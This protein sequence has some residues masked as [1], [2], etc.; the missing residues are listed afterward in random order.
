MSVARRTARARSALVARLGDV[1]EVRA[2]RALQ[3][4]AADGRDVAQLPRGAGQQGGREQRIALPHRAIGGEV[5]V[6]DGGAD[7][8]PAAGEVVDVRVW[9]P[10]DVDEALG[11]LDAE[12]HEVDQVRA[13]AEVH[14]AGLGHG[15]HC[16]RRVG[17]A[18]VCERPHRATSAIA[19]TMFA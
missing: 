3:Q 12:L 13:P 8:Q 9:Q 1:L 19:G 17:R 11:R 15:R 7:P 18:L 5:A 14:R 16:T 6:A 4:V 10:R 2:A